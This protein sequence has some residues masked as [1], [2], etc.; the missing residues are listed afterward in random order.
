MCTNIKDGNWDVSS[1]QAAQPPKRFP[2]TVAR[3]HF[4]ASLRLTC[5]H[6][7]TIMC[8]LFHSSSKGTTFFYRNIFPLILS[9]KSC[10]TDFTQILEDFSSQ[11]NKICSGYMFV[12]E[13]LRPKCS[14]HRM[15]EWQRAFA[16]LGGSE[17][18][19]RICR[20]SPSESLFVWQPQNSAAKRRFAP[21]DPFLLPRQMPVSG[22]LGHIGGDLGHFGILGDLG[23]RCHIGTVETL[24]V[25]HSA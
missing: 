8:K 15:S 6:C 16:I 22:D 3:L 17:E 23:H 4:T 2:I 21:S 18:L 25:N 10:H 20:T 24:N 11:H 9:Q 14:I 13:V 19:F 7:Q 12:R 1:S 5:L